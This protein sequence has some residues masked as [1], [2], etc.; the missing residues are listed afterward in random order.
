M[1]ADLAGKIAIVTRAQDPVTAKQIELPPKT[2]K[3]RQANAF[4]GFLFGFWLRGPDTG[5]I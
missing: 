4:A 3:A 2:T 5:L 1:M